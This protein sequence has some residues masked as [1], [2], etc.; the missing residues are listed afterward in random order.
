MLPVSPQ[1][2]CCCEK[3][4]HEK[5]R[6]DIESST[7]ICVILS[8]Y[9]LTKLFSSL[10]FLSPTLPKS[11]QNTEKLQQLSFTYYIFITFKLDLKHQQNTT[12][13]L[14]D[15]R[16]NATLIFKSFDQHHLIDGNPKQKQITNFNTSWDA[17][18]ISNIFNLSKRPAKTRYIN[19]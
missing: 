9:E 6:W 16:E 15:T 14:T 2:C 3:T 8:F 12:Q 1:C 13:K 5:M 19:L 4:L 17:N 10:I 18:F 7:F 11:R